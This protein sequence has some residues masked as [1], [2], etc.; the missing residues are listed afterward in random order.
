M[1]HVEVVD[2]HGCIKC[3]VSGEF[4]FAD[5][6]YLEEVVQLFDHAEIDRAGS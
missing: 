2:F 1:L 6:I 4:I 3:L 5:P